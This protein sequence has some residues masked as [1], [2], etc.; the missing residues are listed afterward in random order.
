M[1]IVQKQREKLD[2]GQVHR[3]CVAVTWF[4]VS[5][6]WGFKQ[7]HDSCPVL[8]SSP[9]HG[10]FSLCLCCLSVELGQKPKKNNTSAD[11][12]KMPPERLL[13]IPCSWCEVH[14]VAREG[15][16]ESSVDSSNFSLRKSDPSMT[17]DVMS[18]RSRW[19]SL[20]KNNT[21]YQTAQSMVYRDSRPDEVFSAVSVCA[22][23]GSFSNV[24]SGNHV[25]F[26]LIFLHWLNLYWKNLST[27]SRLRSMED[28]F[29]SL[30]S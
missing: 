30:F 25:C 20:L 26:Y 1:L 8:L 21:I 22:H 10:H 5:W 14:S 16:E 12:G 2:Q 27:A 28:W 7:L 17:Y 24:S 11:K 29:K 13:R 18:S 3:C 6:H 4:S 23:E 19:A 15:Q 9:H